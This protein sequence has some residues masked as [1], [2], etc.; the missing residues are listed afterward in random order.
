VVLIISHWVGDFFTPSIY[1]MIIE[2]KGYPFLKP[3][4]PKWAAG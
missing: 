1:D 4:P 2:M 3:D